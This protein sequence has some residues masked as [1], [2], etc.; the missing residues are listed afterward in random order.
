M[1]FPE[2]DRGKKKVVINLVH[3]EMTDQEAYEQLKKDYKE[4]PD[5]YMNPD[6]WKKEVLKDKKRQRQQL[7]WSR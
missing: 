6:E 3:R 2:N 4:N 7:N 5:L 1:R